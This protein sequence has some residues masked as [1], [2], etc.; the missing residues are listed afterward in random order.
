MTRH[1]QVEIEKL[2]KKILSLSAM[3]EERMH[4]AVK[5]IAERNSELA[6][7]VKDSD[8]EID[9]MEVEVEEDCLKILA[10]HQPVAVDLRFLI[11]V[12]KINNDLERIGDLAVSLARQSISLAARPRV[13]IPFDF[14]RMAEISEGM[15]KSAIDALVHLDPEIASEVCRRDDQIDILHRDMYAKVAGGM[16]A[17]PGDIETYIHMLAVSRYLERIADHATNIAEDVIY[18]VEGIITRHRM[19]EYNPPE[20]RNGKKTNS[21]TGL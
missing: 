20:S 7:K 1:L 14:P 5:S 10:L 2:K 12:L 11:A 19:D 6:L 4:M 17:N 15:V 21:P 9:Q 13:A 3:V 16:R 18:M 8:W